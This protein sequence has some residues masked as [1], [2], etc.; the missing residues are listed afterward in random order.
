M[1]NNDG[2]QSLTE[3]NTSSSGQDQS[4]NPK[5]RDRVEAINRDQGASQRLALWQPYMV[6]L[7]L[8]GR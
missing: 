6:N 7:S 5:D 3:L 8:A 4:S 2:H 1:C